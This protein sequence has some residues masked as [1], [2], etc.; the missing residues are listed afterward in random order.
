MMH[1]FRRLSGAAALLAAALLAS[2]ESPTGG[3]SGAPARMDVVA[4]D[5]QTTTA[6]AELPEPLVV[7]V[8][9]DREHPVRG[10]NVNFVV[11]AGGGSSC[12]GA[13]NT[14]QAG[15]A[16]ERWTLG[17]EAGDTQWVDVR[18]VDASTDAPKVFAVL[19]AV[20][21]PGEPATRAKADDRYFQGTSG[22]QMADSLAV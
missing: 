20:A 12:A 15:E 5:L 2:C 9:D 16:R 14:N 13:A 11:T 7:R 3:G 21:T 4:G 19:R 8:L 22:M 10:Q 1:P 17:T 18:E 6:G